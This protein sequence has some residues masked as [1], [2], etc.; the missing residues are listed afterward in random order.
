MQD[1]SGRHR[2]HRLPTPAKS[3]AYVLRTTTPATLPGAAAIALREFTTATPALRGTAAGSSTAGREFEL[4]PHPGDSKGLTG[5]RYTRVH[6]ILPL[7]SAM[8]NPK[9]RSTLA[10]LLV[11]SRESEAFRRAT[12]SA[13]GPEPA[14]PARWCRPRRRYLSGF[15]AAPTLD[16]GKGRAPSARLGQLALC[17]AA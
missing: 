17:F 1:P 9:S 3:S 13:A 6:R 8:G 16:Q 14:P 7:V 12:S 4:F 10:P 11:H 15:Q 2:Q 5:P